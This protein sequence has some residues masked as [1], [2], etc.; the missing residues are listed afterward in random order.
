MEKILQL[1]GEHATLHIQNNVSKEYVFHDLTHTQQVVEAVV[2]MAEEFHFNEAETEMMQIAAWFHD[3]GYDKGQDAHEERS[4]EYA[5][6]FLVKHNYEAEKIA[7]IK[8]AILST[9]MPQSPRTV[10]DKVLCDA[11]MSHLG[12]KTYWERSSKIRQEILL[13]KGKTMTEEE[14]TDFELSFMLGQQY[15]TPIAEMLYDKRKAKNIKQLRKQQSRLNP[16][17]AI[18]VDEIS[19]KVERQ[20]KQEQEMFGDSP[21]KESDSIKEKRLVRGVET[22]F[23]TTYQTHNNLSAMADHKANMMLSINTICISIIAS[24]LIPRIMDGN[25]NRLIVPTTIL[26]VVCLVSMIYAT[27]S[28]RPK[29]TEGN[30]SKEDIEK[31]KAN[32]L[33]FGNFYNMQ[34]PDFQWGVKEMIKD[35]DYLYSTMSKDI[36]FLGVVLAKKYRYLSICYNV[37][38]YGLILTVLAFVVAFMI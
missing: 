9:K 29:V 38:M 30:I 33:F 15:H 8:S 2:E 27:L 13:T 24:T 4:A 26:L 17:E 10:Y 7:H 1:V 6:A 3:M 34:L 32:L 20:K 5:E 25:N 11:D 35:P 14:W 16:Y 23:R 19:E 36:Y 31:R 28:T 22:M 37:F 21:I 12:K 18:T